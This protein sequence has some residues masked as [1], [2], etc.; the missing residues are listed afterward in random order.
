[1]IYH[2]YNKR[3]SGD[4][5]KLSLTTKGIETP[6]AEPVMIDEGP[7]GSFIVTFENGEQVQFEERGA[8]GATMSANHNLELVVDAKIAK[9]LGIT[10]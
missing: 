8:V 2:I 6:G 7:E 10:V 3:K 5:I 1:M 4:E 9:V